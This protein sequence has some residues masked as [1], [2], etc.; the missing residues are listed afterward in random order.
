MT[1]PGPNDCG[2]WSCES[3][4]VGE[5]TPD[6]IRWKDLSPKKSTVGFQGGAN[7]LQITAPTRISTY[8]V[9]I[10]KTYGLDLVV[11]DGES[12]PSLLHL[13]AFGV[14][15][16]PPWSS[17]TDGFGFAGFFQEMGHDPASDGGNVNVFG[18]SVAAHWDSESQTKS[19]GFSLK[20]EEV[21]M[22]HD[23][24]LHMQY[25]KYSSA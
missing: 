15:N 18:L 6:L 12:R 2:R 22:P 14:N 23:A 19:G 20:E 11:W 3:R 7:V 13:A 8:K 25:Q 5:A 9:P 10:H 1:H 17:S 21:R 4:V 16:L 24:L